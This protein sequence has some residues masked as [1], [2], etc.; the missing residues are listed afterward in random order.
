MSTSYTLVVESQEDKSKSEVSNGEKVKEEIPSVGVSD[1]LY[2]VMS[3]V[4]GSK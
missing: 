1:N 3:V 4:I 2:S